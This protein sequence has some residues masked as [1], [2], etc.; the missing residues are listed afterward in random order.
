MTDLTVAVLGTGIMGAGM[1][2]NIAK[3]GIDG[4]GGDLPRALTA[5]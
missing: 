4:H 1:A 2:G 3:A 5:A